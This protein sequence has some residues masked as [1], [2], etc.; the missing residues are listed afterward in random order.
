MSIFSKAVRVPPRPAAPTEAESARLTRAAQDTQWRRYDEP[1]YLRLM[2]RS[3][4]A[5]IFNLEGMK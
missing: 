1:S 3:K 2:P 4:C 5:Q